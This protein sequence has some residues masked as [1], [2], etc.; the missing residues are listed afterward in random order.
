MSNGNFSEERS[1]PIALPRGRLRISIG[2]MMGMIA[3]LALIFTA[4]RIH[5]A[6]AAIV[7]LWSLPSYAR[8]V[9]QHAP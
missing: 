2:E 9:I 8:T 7:S 6:A 3:V 1:V 4:C 5:W